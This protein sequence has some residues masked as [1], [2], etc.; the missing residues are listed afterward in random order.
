MT[1]WY[2]SNEVLRW[3]AI[4]LILNCLCFV[5]CGSF[6]LLVSREITTWINKQNNNKC[7]KYYN[8][9]F[10]TYLSGFYGIFL[11]LICLY[12][13]YKL[14]IWSK[15]KYKYTNLDKKNDHY[16]GQYSDENFLDDNQN[17]INNEEQNEEQNVEQNVE[18]NNKN[19]QIDRVIELSRDDLM[20]LTRSKLAIFIIVFSII[21]YIISLICILNIKTIVSVANVND[22]DDDIIYCIKPDV[23]IVGILLNSLTILTLFLFP[24]V[25]WLFVD[26]DNNNYLEHLCLPER[27]SWLPYLAPILLLFAPIFLPLSIFIIIGLIYRCVKRN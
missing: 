10:G 13:F 8:M 4:P 16:I 27:F 11:G 25:T 6:L 18:Q 5:G 9:V 15:E 22:N 21:I 19:E 7:D 20:Y 17:Q 23:K 26:P 12:I 24:F 2:I 1:R 14:Y 3:F